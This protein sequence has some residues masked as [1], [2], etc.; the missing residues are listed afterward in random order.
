MS[1]S[2]RIQDAS[3][4]GFNKLT[5]ETMYEIVIAV[6]KHIQLTQTECYKKYKSTALRRQMKA[7]YDYEL[8]ISQ[9]LQSNIS[10]KSYDNTT[11][12]IGLARAKTL[13]P[14]FL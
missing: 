4:K 7:Y 13:A 14:L 3:A 6:A 12:K 1:Y 11:S 9:R 5:I 2:L 8:G 10:N